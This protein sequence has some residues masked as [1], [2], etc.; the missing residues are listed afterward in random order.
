MASCALRIL[1]DA[2]DDP[3]IEWADS[4]IGRAILAAGYGK[5]GIEMRMRWDGA[6]KKLVPL[7]KA[8]A[9]EMLKSITEKA[10]AGKTTVINN[11]DTTQDMYTETSTDNLRPPCCSNYNGSEQV[12][13]EVLHLQNNAASIDVLIDS[14]CLQTNIVSAAYIYRYVP[15]HKIIPWC[16]NIIIHRPALFFA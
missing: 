10:Q 1:S 7:E 5:G 14:G 13:V 15:H 3:T 12:L 9:D 8:A 6:R 4:A 2:N 16:L 11:L